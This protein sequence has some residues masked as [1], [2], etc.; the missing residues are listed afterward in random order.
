MPR[1]SKL[2]NGIGAAC[3]VAI[4]CLHPSSLLKEKYEPFLPQQRLEG[5]LAI[6]LEARMMNGRESVCIYFRHDEFPGIELYCCEKFCKVITE[7][8]ATNFFGDAEPAG[9]EPKEQEQRENL[10][11]EVAV[12]A[13]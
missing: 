9:N 13:S 3:S 7:G 4:R 10:P 6:K 5:L 11:A 12:N 1:R 2:N 8:H